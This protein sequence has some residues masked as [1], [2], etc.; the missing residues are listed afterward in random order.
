MFVGV[1][2]QKGKFGNVNII[3]VTAQPQ[4]PPQL[5]PRAQEDRMYT[6]FVDAAL[7]G[8]GSY[9]LRLRAALNNRNQDIVELRH[10][11]SYAIA[12][13]RQARLRDRL[14]FPID[15]A[16]RVQDNI[17]YNNHTCTVNSQ[18][19][20]VHAHAYSMMCTLTK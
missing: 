19:Q 12:Y 6:V 14:G 16:L 17:W 18:A 15:C 20:P 11:R 10:Q 8:R 1:S 5:M 7:G 9:D 2:C 4:H 3:C 13:V